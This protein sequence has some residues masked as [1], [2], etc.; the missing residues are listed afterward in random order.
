MT[1]LARLVTVVCAILVMMGCRPRN[2]ASLASDHSKSAMN[3]TEDDLAAQIDFFAELMEQTAGEGAIDTLAVDRARTFFRSGDYDQ[4]GQQVSQ[5]QMGFL[6]QQYQVNGVLTLLNRL[7]EAGLM[8]ADEV[9]EYSVIHLRVYDGLRGKAVDAKMALS[10]YVLFENGI[11]LRLMQNDSEFYPFAKDLEPLIKRS[12]DLLRKWNDAFGRSNNVD[13]LVEQSKDIDDA[14]VKVRTAYTT[15]KYKEMMAGKIQQ[16]RSFQKRGSPT[17]FIK[18]NTQQ[19]EAAIVNLDKAGAFFQSGDETAAQKFVESAMAGLFPADLRRRLNDSDLFALLT[20]QTVLS[21]VS[22]SC[23]ECDAGAIASFRNDLSAMSLAKEN[24]AFKEAYINA[25]KDLNLVTLR[26]SNLE[27]RTKFFNQVLTEASIDHFCKQLSAYKTLIRATKVNYAKDGDGY[28]TSLA[29]MDKLSDSLDHLAM[30]A[31]LSQDSDYVSGLTVQQDKIRF[32]LF[33]G[34]EAAT[35]SLKAADSYA[36][37]LAEA[38]HGYSGKDGNA[39]FISD[40]GYQKLRSILNQEHSELQSRW[41]KKIII[42]SGFSVLLAAEAVSIVVGG[43]LSASA[44]AGTSA[45]MRAIVFAGEVVVGATRVVV[46]GAS[47][48]NI[49]DRTR[50]Q[51]MMNGLF[52]VDSGLDALTVLSILPRMPLPPVTKGALNNTLGRSIQQGIGSLQYVA[53]SALSVGGA[54]FSGYQFI[55]AESIAADLN[56]QG[57]PVTADEIRFRACSTL[58]MSALAWRANSRYIAKA[59]VN[60]PEVAAKLAPNTP[61][62]ETMLVKRLGGLINPLGAAKAYY[63]ANPTIFRA[64]LG[65]TGIVAAAG[66][67]YLVGSEAILLSYSNTTTNYA[68]Q[69]ESKHPFPDLKVGESALGLV[70]F[71]PQDAMLYFGAFSRGTNRKELGKYK[72]KYSIDHFGD[73]DELLDK[74]AAY[75]KTHGKIKYL[76]IMS[77]GFPGAIYTRAAEEVGAAKNP[78][79][80]LDKLWINARREKIQAVSR[81]AFA[82][83]ARIVVFACLVGSNL[84]Y[85]DLKGTGKTSEDLDKGDTFMRLM[86]DTFLVNGGSIDASKRIL[87]GV[88]TA[89]GD[90]IRNAANA[91]IK[92][93]HPRPMVPVFL[94]DDP[95]PQVAD[96]EVKPKSLAGLTVARATGSEQFFRIQKSSGGPAK[97]LDI[98]TTVVHLGGNV[99][100]Q[101]AQMKEDIMKFGIQLEGP[102]W[103]NRYNYIEVKKH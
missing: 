90:L 94:L 65:T 83:D 96:P 84:D 60:N 6:A 28:Q 10:G 32:I 64:V 52:S 41:N 55:F 95:N 26:L 18:V 25:K 16:L 61:L 45:M 20:M 62:R 102:W 50:S 51:G 53:G 24:F 77:H 4:A 8:T 7:K 85:A 71:A 19:V 39:G 91:G 5:I 37:A 67:D 2:T 73:A 13:S 34:L 54:L 15:V 46:A 14:F 98:T 1:C 72:E 56:S 58:A 97:P 23:S 42:T 68:N 78:A 29:R 36:E 63:A 93:E 99:V 70:G 89:Y 22:S 47:L 86:A 101:L 9:Q 103:A 21:Y 35:Q 69:I 81:E 44:M 33:N 27:A 11:Q 80:W 12:F 3:L 31:R 100:H 76:K 88:D 43:P 75:A 38:V 30:R 57:Y 49:M 48:L 66:F 59:R 92:T 87:N 40:A 82:D 79:S 74:I 17:E